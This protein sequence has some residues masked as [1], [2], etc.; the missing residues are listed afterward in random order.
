MSPAQ[1]L[2]QPWLVQAR[3][4]LNFPQA[5]T[6]LSCAIIRD[7]DEISGLGTSDMAIGG[8]F[9]IGESI[10]FFER[11]IIAATNLILAINTF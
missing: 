6:R 7:A 11:A 2:S 9:V 3:L 4:G 10:L 8:L 5:Q 1:I